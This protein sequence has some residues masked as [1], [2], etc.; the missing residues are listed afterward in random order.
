MTDVSIVL[1]VVNVSQF[2]VFFF[3]LLTKLQILLRFFS[4]LHLQIRLN[5]AL[6]GF[7][8]SKS[9]TA[10]SGMLSMSANGVP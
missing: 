1:M 5:P 4:D 6:A 8:K 7:R 2:F 9:R 3:D 10:L